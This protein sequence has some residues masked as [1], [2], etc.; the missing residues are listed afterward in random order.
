MSEMFP[1]DLQKFVTDKG[2]P[3]DLSQDIDSAMPSFVRFLKTPAGRNV[4]TEIKKRLF[5]FTIKNA[6]REA[7]T[8]HVN[9]AGVNMVGPAPRN[10]NSGNI[11][12][13][14]RRMIGEEIIADVFWDTWN[15]ILSE[16]SFKYREDNNYE[17]LEDT[18]MA[19]WL[20]AGGSKGP[21][22]G[23]GVET[24]VR[25]I[26]SVLESSAG[27]GRISDEY[28][29]ALELA[30]NRHYAEIKEKAN[31]NEKYEPDKYVE[32]MFHK[33][34]SN[35]LRGC[36]YL[37]AG[38]KVVTEWQHEWVSWMLSL[39]TTFAKDGFTYVDLKKR[40]VKEHPKTEDPG[41][42][43][44]FGAPDTRKFYTVD[45]HIQMVLVWL[46]EHGYKFSEWYHPMMNIIVPINRDQGAGYKLAFDFKKYHVSHKERSE[47]KYRP[48]CPVGALP[49]AC[50]IMATRDLISVTPSTAG[51]IGLETP[52]VNAQRTSQFILDAIDNNRIIVPTDFSTYDMKLLMQLCITLGFAEAMCYTDPEVRNIISMQ[53]V[54]VS[55]KL[56]LFP[57]KMRDREM[58]KIYRMHKSWDTRMIKGDPRYNIETSLA[59]INNKQARKQVR[60]KYEGKFD[61]SSRL[62]YI[63]Q[64]YLIS[65][66]I[67]TNS[68]G[69]A[70]SNAM[71]R[72]LVPYW[73][74]KHREDI[75]HGKYIVK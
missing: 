63:F 70:C 56:C 7:G 39:T 73:I 68:L 19:I 69:S 59:G 58:E 29:P 8:S 49:Q 60:D 12:V 53:G 1:S 51:R 54:V 45:D 50:L 4:R 5:N 28:M 32:Y 55:Q 31:E 62:F 15:D 35:T 23:S 57:V 47:R 40:W 30:M 33:Q 41:L 18:E 17:S 44:R 65:G 46:R 37:S 27:E 66:V 52:S 72:D 34:L 74:Y 61:Y 67:V 38:N 20:E 9:I 6:D 75:L 11:D 14:T 22:D 26:C 21:Y 25:T 36:G 48:V 71:A 10:Q 2:L 16:S 43:T 64:K 24:G 13:V 3:C 42:R